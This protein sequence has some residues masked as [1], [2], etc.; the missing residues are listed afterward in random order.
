M[1]IQ[2]VRDHGTSMYEVQEQIASGKK[3]HYPSDDPTAYNRMAELHND[4]TRLDHFMRSVRRLNDDYLEYDSIIQQVAEKAQRVTEMVIDSSD[5]TLSRLNLDVHAEM[6]NLILEDLV[7]LANTTSDASSL[8]AGLRADVPAYAITR[9]AE[10]RIDSVTYQGNAGERQ[11]E[12]ADGITVT[13]N[14]VG[15]DLTGDGGMFQSER[16]D[17]FA[18][19]MQL[20]DRLLAGENPVQSEAFTADAGADTLTVGNVYS[21]GCTVILESNGTLPGGV[22]SGRTYYAIRVSPTE[23]RLANSLADARAGVYV[24]IT[25]AGIGEQGITQQSLADAERNLEHI[26]AHLSALGAREERLTVHE[27]FL[28]DVHLA[29]KVELND[30]ESVDVAEAVTELTAKQVAYEAALRVTM[31]MM[32]SSLLNYM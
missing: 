14:I 13:A 27:A 21:T 22:E 7:V 20:R 29:N 2:Y 5:R 15:T 3:V 12:I 25:D 11:V 32:N 17:I 4:G 26:L 6:V 18:D 8:F 10:G 1:L 24:D 9:D 28:Q 31:Q 23:I 16:V 30:L 19:L